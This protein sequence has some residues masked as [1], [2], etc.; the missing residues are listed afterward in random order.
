MAEVL[1]IFIMFMK[2]MFAG[3][4]AI[5]AFLVFC[6]MVYVAAIVIKSAFQSVFEIALEFTELLTT[7]M[8]GITTKLEEKYK[9]K[10]QINLHRSCHSTEGKIPNL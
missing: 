3:A 1:E 9:S 5:V 4:G 6:V 8:D 7:R 2:V 10:K